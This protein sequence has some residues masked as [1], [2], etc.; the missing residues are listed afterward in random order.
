LGILPLALHPDLVGL[1]LHFAE[2]GLPVGRK[3]A[4]QTGMGLLGSHGNDE[5]GLGLVLQELNWMVWFFHFED[6]LGPFI[7]HGVF[8]LI[9]GK[10]IGSVSGPLVRPHGRL[11]LEGRHA[12]VFNDGLPVFLGVFLVEFGFV[13]FQFFFPLL[14]AGCLF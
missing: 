8:E 14:V 10:G 9:P 7:L 3:A 11:S 4:F 12:I 5:T 13:I 6:L 1:P 2:V